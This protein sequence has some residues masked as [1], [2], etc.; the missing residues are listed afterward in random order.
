ML[1]YYELENA[2]KTPYLE[3]E[4]D[5]MSRIRTDGSESHLDN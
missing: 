1:V 2:V 3:Q 4:V 5:S